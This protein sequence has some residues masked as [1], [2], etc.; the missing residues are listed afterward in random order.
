MMR[1]IFFSLLLCLSCSLYSQESTLRVGMELSNPPFE[2]VCPNGRPCG[3]SPGIADALGKF[4]NKEVAIENIAFVGLI[5]ALN[6]GKIDL[7][8]SS[9]TITEQRKQSIDFSE[10]YATT[11]LCLLINIHSSVNSIEDANQPGRIIVVKS[12]TSGEVYAA[13]HLSQA[14]VR[15]LDKE[16][17]CVLEVIQGKADTF[18]YDQLS[19]YTHWQKNLKTTRALLNPF[20]KEYWGIGV[21]KGNVQLLEQVNLFITK[22]RE[23][24]GFEKLT[25]TYL[26]EQKKALQKLGIP[27]IF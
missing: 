5:P 18:I 14:T 23:E 26:P 4:L 10:P 13:K 20:E 21:R 2:M 3:I 24:G 8:I 16:S 19:V 17:M 12:G 22:F 7:I 6:S 11:G 27:L 25:D 1:G 15:V 9:M